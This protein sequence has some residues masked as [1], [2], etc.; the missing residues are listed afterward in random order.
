MTGFQP[1]V[2]LRDESM[3]H[4]GEAERTVSA[5]QTVSERSLRRAET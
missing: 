3:K 1:L 5:T 2:V 4:A